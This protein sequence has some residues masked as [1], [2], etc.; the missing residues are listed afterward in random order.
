MG[1]KLG[2]VNVDKVMVGTTLADKVMLG[3]T[4]V[5]PT[6]PSEV[7]FPYS[8]SNPTTAADDLGAGLT[9]GLKFQALAAISVKAIRVYLNANVTVAPYIFDSS[10]TVIA[11]GP[12]I[13]GVAGWNRMPLSSAY[14]PTINDVLI[15]GWYQATTQ[16]YV[17]TAGGASSA[18]TS[19]DGKVQTIA[20]GGRYHYGT[21]PLLEETSGNSSAWFG[22]QLAY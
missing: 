10:C 9:L 17:Y 20:S 5:W 7:F 16:K 6:S 1:L 2:T 21:G 12:S 3:S 22:C 19:P 4:Q 11:S 15:M 8:G 14:V 18:L 13:S